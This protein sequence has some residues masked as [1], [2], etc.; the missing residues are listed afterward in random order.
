MRVNKMGAHAG[1][2]IKRRMRPAL[3]LALF[4]LIAFALRSSSLNA[5]VI[6]G[7]VA[8]ATMGDTGSGPGFFSNSTNVSVGGEGSTSAALNQFG[9]Q[10]DVQLSGYAI[11][12]VTSPLLK[13]KSIAGGSLHSGDASQ[14]YVGAMAAYQFSGA[15]AATVTYTYSLTATMVE[16]VDTAA[17]LRAQATFVTGADFFTTNQSDFAE[18]SAFVHDEYE[19][20]QGV[21]GTVNESGTITMTVNPGDEF[22]LV[23]GLQTYAGRSGAITDAFSTWQGALTTSSGV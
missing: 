19:F 8:S 17:F 10:N 2:L 12:D 23:L 4:A 13:G 11:G 6:T 9:S 7:V 16:A 20:T 18:S 3:A 1:S 22:H 15:I 5:D 21:G 14:G